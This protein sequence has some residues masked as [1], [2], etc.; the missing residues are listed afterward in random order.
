MWRWNEQKIERRKNAHYYNHVAGGLFPGHL[1]ALRS[2]EHISSVRLFS[3]SVYGYFAR[4]VRQIVPSL[5]V[6]ALFTHE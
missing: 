3:R 4:H 6:A 1:A 2:R 5:D